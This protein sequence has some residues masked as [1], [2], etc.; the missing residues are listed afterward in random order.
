MRT[1]SLGYRQAARNG[2]RAY[3]K[4][5]L[6]FNDG[7]ELQLDDGDFLEGSPSFTDGTSS[8]GSFDI[9][10]AVIGSFDFVLVDYEGKFSGKD[11][12]NAKIYPS[13]GLYPTGGIAYTFFTEDEVH[14]LY[15]N[16]QM[17]ALAS[18]DAVESP[19]GTI[20]WVDFGEY[21]FVKHKTTGKMISATCYDPMLL[22]DRS[23]WNELPAAPATALQIV[24]AIATRH[25]IN[26]AVQSF[27]NSDL[28][29]SA[30]PGGTM[31]DRQ[32]LAYIVQMCGCYAKM[33]N[34]G[35]YVGWYTAAP[36]YYDRL[37][38]QNL[39][40][41]D[42]T[43]TGVRVYYDD[44]NYL[45]AGNEGYVLEAK[46]N[47]FI[48]SANI[49]AVAALI[50]ANVVGMTFRAGSLDVLS[51]PTIEAG[52]LLQFLDA[53][54]KR[55]TTVITGTIYKPYHVQE[56]LTCSAEE[57]ELDDFRPTVT[58]IASQKVSSYAE[59]L[60]SEA[61]KVATNYLSSDE[62]GVMIADLADGRQT[63][64][65]AT[66]RNV[67]I[68]SDSVDIRHGQ[69][70]L[71]TFGTLVRIGKEEESSIQFTDN[72]MEGTGGDGLQFFRIS[73]NGG[74]YNAV[75]RS[76]YR[77]SGIR[78]TNTAYVIP[79]EIIAECAAGN[80]VYVSIDLFNG[81]TLSGSYFFTCA[82]GT[83]KTS[84]QTVSGI[85][86]TLTYDGSATVNIKWS[87]TSSV[88]SYNT[89]IDCIVSAPTPYYV[90][91][92][93]EYTSY[94]AYAF[95]EGYGNGAT[96]NFAHAEGKGNYA[97]ECSHAEGE[98]TTASDTSHAEGSETIAAGAN[99][100]A[101]GRKSVAGAQ[102]SHAEGYQSRASGDASHA[103]GFMTKAQGYYSHAGG[104]GTIA[105]S[106][107][108]TAIG[109]YNASVSGALFI[110]GKGTSDTARSNAFVV[111]SD[112]NTATSGYARSASG[113]TVTA[114]GKGVWLTD[115]TATRYP[116]L[117]DNGSNLWIGSSQ[118]NSRHH[119]GATYISAGHNGTAGND[120]I[121]VSVPNAANDNGT[122]YGVYHKGN[123]TNATTS[124]AGLMSA[125]DKTQVSHLPIEVL[126]ATHKSNSYVGASDFR[127]NPFRVGNIVIT[128]IN[129]TLTNAFPKPSGSDFVP[130]GTIT[131]ATLLSTARITV[132]TTNSGSNVGVMI[133][134]SGEVK[135][136]NHSTTNATGLI[137]CQLIQKCS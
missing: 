108:Q 20:E 59:E 2:E 135:I 113:F 88:Y 131:G 32:V 26:M 132:P 27:P 85:T 94:G 87:T 29:I 72:Q 46:G 128:D 18:E 124:S 110:V 126:T 35:L 64:S 119:R 4:A 43:V 82:Y 134:T 90:F 63:P 65:T 47:P 71:A 73:G 24:S 48:T 123:L 77:T 40:T 9:G 21:Y 54:S 96:G 50:A 30:Y 81:T 118:T 99:S 1:S 19:S 101:E 3:L 83:S 125:A 69:D 111:D 78:T 8:S 137:R 49:T 41:N 5:R 70:V 109:K 121:Y 16:D 25:G 66:G 7:T 122:N 45:L 51:D 80:K 103:E 105:S 130:I 117:Y 104:I 11:F 22:L 23:E 114:T 39:H 102:Y 86:A 52:D 116:A 89:F 44:N 91:G 107:A 31:T 42:I 33:T 68:D 97:G 6:V 93:C 112:G 84:T 106:E 127:V 133:D 60:A 75:K 10:G 12:T 57:E 38:T 13:V 28:V 76:T 98:S 129:C 95:V 92:Y 67:F 120:T 79:S 100:H 61:E 53:N 56:T 58:E 74:R 36:R 115:L 37:F 17:D 62:T 136:Y 34:A 15:T 55:L 14:E